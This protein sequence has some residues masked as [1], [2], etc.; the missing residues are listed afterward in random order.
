MSIVRSFRLTLTEDSSHLRHDCSMA[1][2]TVIV[3]R[4]HLRFRM[5]IDFAL[6]WRFL[7]RAL[8]CGLSRLFCDACGIGFR[9]AET[10]LDPPS[11]PHMAAGGQR[12]LGAIR[13]CVP[14]VRFRRRY[15]R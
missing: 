5:L 1:A 13:A 2:I 14:S 8:G 6:L 4:N 9:Y 10:R 3:A 11:R 7:L 15:A 12:E